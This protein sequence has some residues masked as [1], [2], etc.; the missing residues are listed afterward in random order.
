MTLEL[1]LEQRIQLYIAKFSP[2][3]QPSDA[4]D[5]EQRIKSDTGVQVKDCS[6]YPYYDNHPDPVAHKKLLKDVQRALQTG[7]QCLIGKG[8][9]GYLNVHHEY[10][11]YR[12]MQILE[13]KQNKTFQCVADRL[14]AN[15][16]ATSPKQP[17]FTDDSYPLLRRA[18]YPAV[19]LDTYRIGG[20]LST[21]HDVDTYR[22][23]FNLSDSQIQQH[24]T[25]HPLRGGDMHRFENLPA[26]LF[27]EMVHWL[28]HEHNAVTPDMAHL[29]E[30]CCFGGS[31]FISDPKA[32]AEYQ[33]Q[34]C[35]ILKDDELW[36]ASYHKYRE[37]QLWHYKGYDRLK[38]RMREDYD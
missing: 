32:N 38:T 33:Q 24:L 35:N 8:P 17:A 16:V 25:G 34:A 4:A 10:Q 5:A 22:D 30:T 14:Y 7:M 23:F 21:S 11:A 13:S 3:D 9:A 6:R 27:H 1:P 26:L 18:G 19:I 29:Y 15:A 31:D 2:L 37:M 12:L 20:L 28:G 36:Q